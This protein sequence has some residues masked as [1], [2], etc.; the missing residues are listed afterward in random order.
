MFVIYVALC[1][2]IDIWQFKFYFHAWCKLIIIIFYHK[3]SIV[4]YI[5]SN[6]EKKHDSNESSIAIALTLHIYVYLMHQLSMLT[7][8]NKS[9]AFIKILVLF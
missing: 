3:R 5:V 7:K 1:M 4:E 8:E 6:L 2:Q 9:L